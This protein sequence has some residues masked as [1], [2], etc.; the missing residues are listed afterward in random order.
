M[1][2]LYKNKKDSSIVRSLFYFIG[3][4]TYKAKT[5]GG[6]RTRLNWKNARRGES[7]SRLFVPDYNTVAKLY[8]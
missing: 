3:K 2:K 5:L 4:V 1:M 8:F 7:A 6:M